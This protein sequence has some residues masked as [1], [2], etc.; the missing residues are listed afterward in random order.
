MNKF[1]LIALAVG[2]LFAGAAAGFL[3]ARNDDAS[4]AATFS[5]PATGDTSPPAAPDVFPGA[6][7]NY[8]VSGTFHVPAEVPL[9]RYLVTPTGSPF[10]CTWKTQTKNDDAPKHLLKVGTPNRGSSDEVVI[11]SS[12]HYLVLLGDCAVRFGATRAR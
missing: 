6:T 5:S 9:G 8:V 10:G 1:L 12:V 7:L 2:C 11:D 3:S 4:S